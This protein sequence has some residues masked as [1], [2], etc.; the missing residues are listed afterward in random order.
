M[1]N[2]PQSCTLFLHAWRLWCDCNSRSR[3]WGGSVHQPALH[4]PAET[5]APSPQEHPLFSVKDSCTAHECKRKELS[6]VYPSVPS[7]TPPR[8]PLAIQ[9][10]KKTQP[11]PF[12]FSPQCHIPKC[13]VPFLKMPSV[14]SLPKPLLPPR[15]SHLHHLQPILTQV[16]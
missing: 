7:L 1:F 10:L 3:V 6:H 12:P 4:G 2:V 14:C 13:F 8:R 5:T 16:L 9:L 11:G 15:W